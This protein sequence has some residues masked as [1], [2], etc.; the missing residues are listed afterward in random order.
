MANT[1]EC[2]LQTCPLSAAYI[3]Y[4]PNMPGNMVYLAIFAVLM[5]GQVGAGI[6]YRTWSFMVPMAAGLILEVIGYLGR[7]FL[8]NNPFN[9]D[10]FLMYLICLTIAPAFFT[11]GIYLCLGRVITVYG[12]EFSRLKPRTYT[13]IFVAC[14]LISLVLQ[15]AGGA[16]TSI[17]DERS[18]R[19]TG[20]NI[21]IA[22]LAF[23]VVS[24]VAFSVLAIEYGVRAVRA[25]RMHSQKRRASWKRRS[26][27]LGLATAVLTI[28]IRSAFRV[29]ELQRGFDS[30][31]ANDEVALM[32]LEGAMVSIACICLTGLYPALLVGK[33]W[34]TPRALTL[35]SDSETELN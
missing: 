9:F 32:I 16:V 17:A 28:V 31:L 1:D 14:D 27:L 23:Q 19:D 25:R 8:H 35:V 21:M 12:E 4:R 34:K 22:G 5:V 29:A 30:S 26:F 15:A 20:V 10:A 2:T 18:L 33:N 6:K 13:Y 24:L 3:E 11:A 7:V